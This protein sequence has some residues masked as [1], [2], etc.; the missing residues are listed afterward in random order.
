MGDLSFRRRKVT[1]PWSPQTLIHTHTGRTDGAAWSVWQITLLVVSLNPMPTAPLRS[2][3][4]TVLCGENQSHQVQAQADGRATVSHI[5]NNLLLMYLAWVIY[6]LG[7]QSDLQKHQKHTFK[8]KAAK[9]KVLCIRFNSGNLFWSENLT[10]LGLGISFLEQ[11]FSTAVLDV[12]GCPI[13]L[14]LK[15]KGKRWETEGGW[16]VWGRRWRGERE[17]GCHMPVNTPI[18]VPREGQGDE[19]ASLWQP[20]DPRNQDFKGGEK[21]HW[22]SG[23]P[24]PV[25]IYISLGR[26]C[27]LTTRALNTHIHT[28]TYACSILWTCIGMCCSSLEEMNRTRHPRPVS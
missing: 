22:V 26:N 12:A 20:P 7:F 17:G 3:P 1:H 14:E 15:L 4:P 19:G 11:Y 10:L 9:Y 25:V 13:F 28:H 18:K 6:I 27:L 23:R 8:T 2:T 24:P 16:E 21:S 5:L